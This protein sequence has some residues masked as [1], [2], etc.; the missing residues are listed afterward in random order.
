MQMAN[1]QKIFDEDISDALA[2]LNAGGVILYPTDTIW[3]LGCD[4]C[5]AEAVDRIFKIKQRSDSK[6]MLCLVDCIGSIPGFVDD[7]P[8]QAWELAELAETPLT[9]IYPGA[10]NLAPNLIAEDGSV[11]IRITREDFSRELCARF[12]R[13][14][15]STSANISGSPSPACF[16][17]IPESLISQVDY[18]VRYRREEKEKRTAS[19]I[20]KF[21]K[22]GTF[23]IIR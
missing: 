23:A 17:D 19:S 5:N 9:I 22:N 18:V 6:S 12:R 7:V 20:I 21:E 2:T 3:G 15:V 13:P 1:N 16:A 4:S 8:E 14:L 10:K 11:G